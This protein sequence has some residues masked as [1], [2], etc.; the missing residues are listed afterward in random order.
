MTGKR[1]HNFENFDDRG[2]TYFQMQVQFTKYFIYALKHS[3]P[4]RST[5][6]RWR[7]LRVSLTDKH[8]VID[9]MHAVLAQDPVK[10]WENM[11]TVQ[12]AYSEN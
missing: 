8:A 11:Q 10:M 4:N 5:T 3:A 12:R 9:I 7:K 1:W 6:D 2:K